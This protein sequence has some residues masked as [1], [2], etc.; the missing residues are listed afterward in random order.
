[1]LSQFAS[2]Y[3]GNG[4]GTGYNLRIGGRESKVDYHFAMDLKLFM[5]K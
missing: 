5:S 3:T 2:G 1:L 4:L